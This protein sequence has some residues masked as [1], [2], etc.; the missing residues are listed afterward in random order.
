MKSERKPKEAGEDVPE[1]EPRRTL[2]AILSDEEHPVHGCGAWNLLDH[3][4]LSPRPMFSL[5]ERIWNPSVDVSETP[6]RVLIRMDIAG[7]RPGDFSV[8]VEQGVLTIRGRRQERTPEHD[9]EFHLM[10]IR[11]GHFERRFLIS[12]SIVS[13]RI[14]AQYQDGFLDIEIPKGQGKGRS[15]TIEITE[16][17][18]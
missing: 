14:K 13:D 7:V 10:E 4:F 18:K 12:S 2:Q 16:D 1:Q 6:D 5:S 3:F 9:E 11:H 15:V 8:T 17:P